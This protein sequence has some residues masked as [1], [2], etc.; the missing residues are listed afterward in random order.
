MSFAGACLIFETLYNN[1]GSVKLRGITS[2]EGV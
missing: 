2:Y 1:D